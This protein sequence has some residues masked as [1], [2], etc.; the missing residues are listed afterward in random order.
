[1]DISLETI[2]D[3]APDQASLN[4]AKKLI[5]PG[6]W[7]LTGQASSVNS[8]W[9][10]CQGSGANPYYTMADV[11]DHG[12]KCT[13]PSRKFP[14]KHVLALL[15][16]Y[17]D[18]AGRFTESEPPEWVADWLGRRRKTTSQTSEPDITSAQK[19]SRKNIHSTD[20]ITDAQATESHSPEELAKKT[21]AKAAR[22]LKARE[23]SDAGIRA[24]L[25]DFQQWVD[26]QLRTGIA[27]MLK[28]LNSRCRGMAARLVDAKAST[29]A[30]RLD[31]LPAKALGKPAAA[32][33]T[34]VLRE[35]GQ[36]ILLSE[37]WLGNPDDPDAR[38]AITTADNREQV[39]SAPNVERTSGVW[40]NI[41][42]QIHTRRDGLISHATWLIE[43]TAPAAKIALLQDYY[44]ASVGRR[45]AGLSVGKFVK[46][47]VV[48]YPSR[49]PC[50][51]F[52]QN[53][54][55]IEADPVLC[56]TTSMS[57]TTSMWPTTS[58]ELDRHY[59]QQQSLIPWAEQCPFVLGPGRIRQDKSGQH[60]WLALDS[61]RHILIANPAL[62]GVVMGDT[63]ERAF[64]IWDG[65]SATLLSVQSQCWGTIV[66]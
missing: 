54:E 66:C 4:A 22:L 59:L 20:A 6:K 52:L 27:P 2:Q 1:M 42:E 56:P 39:L 65:N 21:A 53:Y 25:L 64:I 18:D 43:M 5:K 61:S 46:G 10:Q 50:R 48:F 40:Q 31:E 32:Q 19:P 12:Y 33:A 57:P 60:W 45:E 55:F 3:L 13:C 41:G 15:W 36:L 9:G 16:Q 29:L 28:E 35:L 24:G 8:I 49:Q 14:C 30:S 58:M 38:G 11:V 7:P 37:A 63:L 62:P 47:D 51:G 17:A 44:P 23:A 26:D 34:T